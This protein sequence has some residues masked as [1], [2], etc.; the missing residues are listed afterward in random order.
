MVVVMVLL[1]LVGK[2]NVDLATCEIL[3]GGFSKS[4]RIY[5]IVVVLGMVG[6][7]SS[8]ASGDIGG[9]KVWSIVGLSVIV[10]RLCSP[11]YR[12]SFRL[13]VLFVT[14]ADRF[15]RSAVLSG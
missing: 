10:S 5:M 12:R 2:G 6:E 9:T 3:R 1:E 7:T 4:R 13:H 8:K 15:I 11:Q 14:L